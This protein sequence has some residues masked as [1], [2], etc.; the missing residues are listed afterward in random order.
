MSPPRLLVVDPEPSARAVLRDHLESQA[1]RVFEAE[2]CARARARFLEG[3]IAAVV[4]DFALPDGEA[5]GLLP[6]FKAPGAAVPVIVLTGLDTLERAVGALRLGA[7]HFLPK[8]PEMA[9][10]VTL[11][12]RALDPEHMRRPAAEAPSGHEDLHLTLEQV[13]RRHIERVLADEKGHVERTAH[14]LAVPRSS[15][16]EMIRRLGIRRDE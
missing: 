4:T 16:Y 7:D 2:D 8:P 9:T 15:L 14:R 5:P 6:V 1:W 13:E 10:L 11:L 3:D 12:R